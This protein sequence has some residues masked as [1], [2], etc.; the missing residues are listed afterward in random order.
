M[1]VSAASA[2]L[3]ARDHVGFRDARE[4]P[5][6]SFEIARKNSARGGGVEAYRCAKLG[7]PEL[8]SSKPAA[9]DRS[10]RQTKPFLPFTAVS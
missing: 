5:L 10:T 2:A 1:N 9:Q 8:G 7:I 3:S 6:R 4:S